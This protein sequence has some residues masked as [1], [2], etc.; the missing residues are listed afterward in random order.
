MKYQNEEEIERIKLSET[1]V[2]EPVNKI[3][4]DKIQEV[5]MQTVEANITDIADMLDGKLD[6]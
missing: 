3:V 1:V 6:K 5:T 4:Q 2:Q